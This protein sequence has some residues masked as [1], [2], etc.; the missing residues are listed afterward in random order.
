MDKK[1][2]DYATNIG[3]ALTTIHGGN[4]NTNNND[5]C[6]ADDA[7]LEQEREER[8]FE[9]RNN[10]NEDTNGIKSNISSNSVVCVAALPTHQIDD[11]I[12]NNQHLHPLVEEAESRSNT[13]ISGMNITDDAAINHTSEINTDSAGY[14]QPL[15][16]TASEEALSS[17]PWRMPQAGTPSTS[18][19]ASQAQRQLLD[20]T[21][22]Q[23]THNIGD[24]SNE[25]SNRNG[26]LPLFHIERTQGRT[27]SSDPFVR[28]MQVAIRVVLFPVFIVATLVG[29]VFILIFC[30]TPMFLSLL[31]VLF[32][33]YCCSSASFNG[34]NSHG[35]DH[36]PFHVLVR[37]IFDVDNFDNYGNDANEPKY[38]REQIQERL[39]RRRILSV[40]QL[41]ASSN[42]ENENDNSIKSAAVSPSPGINNNAGTAS[43]KSSSTSHHDKESDMSN[44][45]TTDNS[46]SFRPDMFPINDQESFL[47]SAENLVFV[48]MNKN[49]SIQEAFIFSSPLSVRSSVDD[50]ETQQK[51]YQAE[52][53]KSNKRNNN[54]ESSNEELASSNEHLQH[55]KNNEENELIQIVI[56][57][58]C[59]RESDDLIR[60]NSYCLSVPLD[61][62]IIDTPPTDN[63]YIDS[64]Q[65]L[66]KT[67]VESGTDSS[68]VNNVA[69][70]KKIG[71]NVYSKSAIDEN[72]LILNDARLTTVALPFPSSTLMAAASPS[73]IMPSTTPFEISSST[74]ETFNNTITNVRAKNNPCDENK[75]N[76][77]PNNT[78]PKLPL[79]CNKELRHGITTYCNICLL[80]YEQGDNIAWSKRSDNS[81]YHAFHEDCILDWLCRKQTCP[82]CRQDYVCE[83]S[84]D[85]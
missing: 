58:C 8:K 45:D 65:L 11:Q 50:D 38:S 62:E 2:D 68:I 82:I 84:P 16:S 28:V 32:G 4:S 15:S 42:Y 14:S 37:Q 23:S 77:L 24:N 41:S 34:G 1:D 30:V 63:E 72:S 49:D 29:V 27:L 33:Y 17:P 19:S 22:H 26:S 48:T 80:N 31:A 56:D 43:S 47:L 70:S 9:S 13:E 7:A 69:S 83:N 44:E 66:T 71:S 25:S 6:C 85:V 79:R 73:Q 18:S 54:Q 12:E 10:K 55:Q 5:D 51:R 53:K 61:A 3:I 59:P 81:C 46:R 76:N 64:N 21:Y 75:Q 36:I 35:G 52:K 60:T 57:A 20:S 39:I 78:L 74:K 40:I 67:L